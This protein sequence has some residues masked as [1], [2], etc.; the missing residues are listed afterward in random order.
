[1][2]GTK[3]QYGETQGKSVAYAIATQQAHKLGRTPKKGA[4][5]KGMYG[6]REGKAAA[7]S[8][9]RDP[10]S[11]YKKTA[12]APKTA[13]FGIL[14]K[15]GAV[16]NLTG[17]DNRSPFVG[18]TQFP[19]EG[20]KS[21]SRSLLSGGSA[22]VGPNPKLMSK[23]TWK[24]SVGRLP[25]KTASK[26]PLVEYIS[27]HAAQL[28]TNIEK[29]D[30]AGAPPPMQSEESDFSGTAAD[31]KSKED[32]DFLRSLFKNNLETPKLR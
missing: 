17:R 21:F 27:K 11:S 3:D 28:E 31:K 14:E 26:D 22:E 7:L 25:M 30:L 5:P 13:V 24:S 15:I 6:T 9:H 23:G 10:K 19:T 18:S 12:S 32:D 8:K 29:M 16:E 20:S 1:M 2:E 4:G